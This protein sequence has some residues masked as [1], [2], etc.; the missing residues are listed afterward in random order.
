MSLNGKNEC[1]K[2]GAMETWPLLFRWV[3]PTEFAK[4]TGPI[5]EQIHYKNGRNYMI[6]IGFA[7]MI[8]GM[9]LVAVGVKKG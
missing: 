8:V 3:N 2:A 5:M 1:S 9:I 7:L 4:F 6:T